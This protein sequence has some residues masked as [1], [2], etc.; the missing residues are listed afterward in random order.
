[1]MQNCLKTHIGKNM[2]VYVDDIVIKSRKECTLLADINETFDN[3]RS[4]NI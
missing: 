3:L 2:E 4:Y 1:M